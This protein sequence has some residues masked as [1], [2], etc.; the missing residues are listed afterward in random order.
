ML[1][2]VT[3][4]VFLFLLFAPQRVLATSWQFVYEDEGDFWDDLYYL[5]TD[6]VYR[7][8]GSVYYWMKGDLSDID[9]DGVIFDY[10]QSDCY[11]NT[12]RIVNYKESETGPILSTKDPSKWYTPELG[13][14]YGTDEVHQYV[15]SRYY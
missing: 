13:K 4:L 1:K 6:S 14:G 10:V 2:T 9:G 8:N 12:F 11:S 7:E 3:I 5:D 15:C